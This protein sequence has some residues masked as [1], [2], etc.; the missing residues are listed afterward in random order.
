MNRPWGSAPEILRQLLPFN[1][2]W[3]TD[4]CTRR[5]LTHFRHPIKGE[6]R[7]LPGI[8]YSVIIGMLRER[9]ALLEG[10]Q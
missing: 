5:A 7:L 4:S 8:H 2:L 6:S 9:L 1:N 10:G 3:P